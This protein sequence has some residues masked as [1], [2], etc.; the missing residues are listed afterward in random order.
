MFK[1]TDSVSVL[2][3][4]NAKI[5]RIN[6]NEKP[7]FPKLLFFE[8]ERGISSSMANYLPP[9]FTHIIDLNYYEYC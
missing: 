1:F 8:T 2:K 5:V 9:Q 4:I 6:I 3:E 7:N